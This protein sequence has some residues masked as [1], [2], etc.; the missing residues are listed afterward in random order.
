MADHSHTHHADLLLT[1]W[2]TGKTP[3]FGISVT[4]LFNTHTL[5]EAGVSEGSV[6]L[7]VKHMAI[8]V[9]R[10]KTSRNWHLSF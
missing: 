4:S 7:A 8:G 6:A 10:P 2:A 5:M 3:A 1:N 9:K